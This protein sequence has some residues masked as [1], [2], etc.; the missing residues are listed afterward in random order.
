LIENDKEWIE[1]FKKYR[2][3]QHYGN[4]DITA[5]RADQNGNFELPLMPHGQSVRAYL[6]VVY[7]NLYSFIMDFMAAALW[8]RIPGDALV[9]QSN[10]EGHNRIFKLAVDM[11][12]LPPLSPEAKK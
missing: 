8:S 1:A 2:D 10:G 12:K 5:I 4:L 9:F 6:N 7:E 11:S 3:D